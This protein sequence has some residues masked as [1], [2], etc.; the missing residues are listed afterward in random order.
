MENYKDQEKMRKRYIKDMNIVDSYGVKWDEQTFVS[1]IIQNFY[2]S[3]LPEEFDKNVKIEVKNS[4]VTITGPKIFDRKL[5]EKIGGTVKSSRSAGGFGEGFKIVALL[6]LRDFHVSIIAQ[7]GRYIIIPF[8]KEAELGGKKCRDLCY[9]ILESDEEFQGS[10]VEIKNC[11]NVLL[12]FFRNGKNFFYYPQNPKL[13]EVIYS[14]SKDG[15]YIHRSRP[16]YSEIY[17]RRQFRGKVGNFLF[18]L[19]YEDEIETIPI[20]RDRR[21]ITR[22]QKFAEAIGKKL[23]KDIAWKLLEETQYLWEKGSQI[24]HGFIDGFTAKKY[25]FKF[26]KDWLAAESYYEDYD[27]NNYVRR[28]NLKVASSYFGQIGMKGASKFCKEDIRKKILEPSSSESSKIRIL[29]EAYQELTGQLPFPED[30]KLIETKTAKGLWT[31]NCILLEK[32]LLYSDFASAMAIYLHEISHNAGKDGDAEFSDD[33]TTMLNFVIMKP[34]V[35]KKFEKE[36]NN[37]KMEIKAKGFI[38]HLAAITKCFFLDDYH[39]IS[40][41]K[42]GTIRLWN[43]DGVLVKTIKAGTGDI[44]I[45]DC[46][47]NLIVVKKYKEIRIFDIE[48]S[49]M[50]HH[51]PEK[52]GYH[53]VKKAYFSSESKQVINIYNDIIEVFDLSKNT[54][55]SYFE[56]EEW[57]SDAWLFSRRD[58]IVRRGHSLFINKDI[59]SVGTKQKLQFLLFIEVGKDYIIDYFNSST[60]GTALLG[61]ADSLYLVSIQEK[62]IRHLIPPLPISSAYLFS[63]YSFIAL[64]SKEGQVFLWDFNNERY[65]KLPNSHLAEVTTISASSNEEWI[66][67]GGKDKI[68]QIN[69][70][71]KLS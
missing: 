21:E 31:K 43:F 6:A 26:S 16:K 19:C 24:L 59:F 55:D 71:P 30:V 23:P 46:M 33:L 17:Y 39:I 14:S 34:E 64:G 65:E 28:L 69:K 67:S 1:D 10:K 18:T 37:Q 3:V 44:E 11:N 66:C 25:K 13:G 62:K 9:E 56:K 38:G 60:D 29:K 52:E 51:F 40:S 42:D 27:A 68:I 12:N 48:K 53:Y 22:L 20:D 41:S 4:D 35:I 47:L 45:T 57:I 61:C 58:L 50:L 63:L 49:E 36:W 5:L 15:V 54:R 70:V 2:D 32:N 8:F 7:V